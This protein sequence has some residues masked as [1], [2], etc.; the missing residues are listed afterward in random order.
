MQVIVHAGAHGTEE[1][2]VM[3]TLLRNKDLFLQYGTSVPGPAKYRT[4]LKESIA[5]AQHAPPSSDAAQVLWDSILEE[6]NATRVI[7]SNAH[8]FGSQ[9]DAL[10]GNMLYPEAEV[11]LQTMSQ[12]LSG[13]G[14]HL[15]LAIRSPSG[16]LPSLLEKAGP[17]RRENV[18]RNTNPLALS[19]ADLLIRIRHTV[20][21]MDITV[22]C[23]EDLPL[24]WAQ[25]LRLFGGLD[26]NT[27]VK[28]GLDVLMSI[29]SREGAQRLR[30]YLSDHPDMTE[31][32]K[33]RI[34]MAFLDKYAKD[35][36][37]EEELDIPGWGPLFM[38]DIEEHYDR[39]VDRISAIPGVNL[40]SP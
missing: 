22:W 36:A 19:W 35:D 25:I 12:L 3:K 40:L 26:D 5:A 14:L 13:D 21:Q 24:I 28:G 30:Q 9:A 11:R 8:F 32:Y 34:F 37:I 1:D 4:L 29:M 38:R 16:F 17:A 31:P 7:L 23:H 10:H 6:E 15:F 39:D 18:I 2:R 20:P 33:R 27:K